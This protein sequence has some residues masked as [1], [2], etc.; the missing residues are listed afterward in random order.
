MEKPNFDTHAYRD[1]LAQNLREIRKDD[2]EMAQDILDEEKNL[3]RYKESEKYNIEE[4]PNRVEFFEE[5]RK[6]ILDGKLDKYFEFKK[7]SRIYSDGEIANV[8]HFSPDEL[9]AIAVKTYK[10]NG[11]GLSSWE[12]LGKPETSMMDSRFRAYH[13]ILKEIGFE[14]TEKEAGKVFCELSH[15]TEERP[16]EYFGKATQ[17]FHD[18]CEKFGYIPVDIATAMSLVKER[19]RI[20]WNDEELFDKYDDPKAKGENSK[21]YYENKYKEIEATL[22]K[23]KDIY[24]Y[25]QSSYYGYLR[26]GD[27][28]PE[29]KKK[30]D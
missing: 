20:F 2:P 12:L 4:R 1:S 28:I 30:E 9:H 23:A 27:K 24:I 7:S 6:S 19:G 21:E 13:R 11:E 3:T 10:D 14:P 25:Q 16:K 26:M 15:G 29:K 5:L 18:V 22:Q 17:Y 8:L